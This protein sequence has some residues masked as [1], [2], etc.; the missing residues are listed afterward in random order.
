[1]ASFKYSC[2][3]STTPSKKDLSNVSGVVDICYGPDVK[4]TCIADGAT[5][6]YLDLGIGVSCTGYSN[7]KFD[8]KAWLFLSKNS[9]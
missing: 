7:G 3:D 9:S 1:M 4:L 5:S 2:S 8:F 6:V